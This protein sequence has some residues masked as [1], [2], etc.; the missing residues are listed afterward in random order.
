V[1]RSWLADGGGPTVALLYAEA[2]RLD[3]AGLRAWA[4]HVTAGAAHCSR[5]YCFPFGLVAIHDAEVGADIERVQPC[6]GAFVESICTPA[7]RLDPPLTD[8]EAI[9]MWSSKE[10]LAKGLGDAV[11]CDPR[12]LQSP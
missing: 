8:V 5:S 11:A 10:A 6:D 9:S 7:E 3:R 2:A 1:R 12:R 4:H